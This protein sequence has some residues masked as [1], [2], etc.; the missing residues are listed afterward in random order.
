MVVS[1]I[2]RGSITPF[3]SDAARPDAGAELVFN[4]R[5]RDTE[6][7]RP[8]VAL[9]YE[10]YPGMADDELRALA[11]ETCAR[12][13]VRDLFVRHRVGRVGVGEASL[14]VAIWSKHR[15]EGIGAMTWFIAELKKRVPIWKWAILPDG[16]RVPSACDHAED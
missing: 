5:V 7:G 15:K 13:P 3:P 8:I 4:G 11:E 10:H 16:S 9:E 14:H 1:E 6:H 2:V 12:F